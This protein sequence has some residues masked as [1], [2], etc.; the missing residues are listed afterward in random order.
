M[1]LTA[2]GTAAVKQA[3]IRSAVTSTPSISGSNNP[4]GARSVGA[5]VSPSKAGFA[6]I[7]LV[8]AVNKSSS[9][10]SSGATKGKG[11]VKLEAGKSSPDE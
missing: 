2:M 5:S 6:D 1:S 3:S 11:K 10:P 4:P 7:K 9:P 8:S